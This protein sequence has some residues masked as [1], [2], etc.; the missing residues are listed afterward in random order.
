MILTSKNRLMAVASSMLAGTLLLYGCKDFLTQNAVPQGAVTGGT[1][2]TKSGVEG[3]LIAAYRALDCNYQTGAWGCAVSNWVFGSVAADDAYEGSQAGDQPGI[4]QIELY[5]WTAPDAEGYLDA[6]WQAMYDGVSRANATLRLLKQVEALGPAAISATDAK[7]IRGE[8]TFLRAHYEFEAY[9]MWGSV[10]YYRENDTTDFRLPNET[11]TAVEAD[12]LK[13]LND[14]IG[15]LSATP[16]NGDVGR[17]TSWTA[18]AYKGRVQVYAGD[19]AGALTTLRDIKANGPYALE[20]SFD[21][22][23]TGFQ[24]LENGKETIFAYQASANDGNGD[25]ENSNFGERLNFPSAGSPFGCCGFHQP[26]QNLV[27]YFQVDPQGLP[28]ALSSPNS[29]NASNVNFTPSFAANKTVAV[30]PRLDWTVGR[31]AV[32]FKDWGM[33]GAGWVRSIQHGGFYSAKKNTHESASGAQSNVGWTNTQLNSVNIHIFRYGDLLLMLAEAEAQA[34]VVDNA[35]LLVNQ[36]RSRAAQTVQGCGLPTDSKAKDAELAEYP[37]CGTDPTIASMAV[38]TGAPTNVT[39]PVTFTTP[40]ATYKIGTYTTAWTD[41]N[42]ALA[43]IQAE[44]RVELA[45]EGQR[46]FDLRRWGL[47]QTVLNGYVN[48]IG[49]GAEKTRLM[50][51]PIPGDTVA[52]VQQFTSAAPVAA[53]HNFYPIPDNQIQLSRVSGKSTLTQNPGW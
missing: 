20:T 12:I 18:K 36:I 51:V 14:A 41:K 49:G 40:W 19:Y 17:A 9:R 10:P 3:M 34:G 53:K 6:K 15:L 23:W 46:F 21:K 29:W 2:T 47:A 13:D 30:D 25:G 27:N 42:T 39:A 45:M 5:Q 37:T 7:G 33:H 1:L 35:R 38:A 11:K 8:A 16:R 24:S 31:D 52:Y 50:Q 22:V 4:E 48:G 26:S 28:I 44:R 32:P 43:A